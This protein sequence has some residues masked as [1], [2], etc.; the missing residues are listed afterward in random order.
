[1]A[2]QATQ[3]YPLSLFLGIPETTHPYPL[4]LSLSYGAQQKFSAENFTFLQF[5]NHLSTAIPS[6]PTV[7]LI[8]VNE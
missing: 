7:G 1:M 4:S 6:I 3:A 8:S 2:Y 5:S